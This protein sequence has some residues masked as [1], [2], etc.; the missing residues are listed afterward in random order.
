MGTLTPLAPAHGVG[1]VFCGEAGDGGVE[2]VAPPRGKHEPLRHTARNDGTDRRRRG[3][4]GGGARPA[5]PTKPAVLAKKTATARRKLA[6]F[7]S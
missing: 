4:S 2:A 6:A 7:V 3:H 5:A 1:G